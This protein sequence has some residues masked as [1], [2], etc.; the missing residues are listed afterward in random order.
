MH[1]SL[2]VGGLPCNSGNRHIASMQGLF[3]VV[4]SRLLSTSDVRDPTRTP[5]TLWKTFKL[6]AF[7]FCV[8]C[9]LVAYVQAQVVRNPS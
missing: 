6:N 1:C 9:A 4:V 3:G 2:F 7:N 8:F 5:V